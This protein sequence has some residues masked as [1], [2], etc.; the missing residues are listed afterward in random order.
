MQALYLHF[1]TLQYLNLQQI[2]PTFHRNLDTYI[3]I[4]IYFRTTPTPQKY[5][6]QYRN[7]IGFQTEPMPH[8]A[9]SYLII[10][11]LQNINKK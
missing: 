9:I 6:I 5:Q 11:Y 7:I 8:S 2:I 3:F 4:I 1:S 10:L